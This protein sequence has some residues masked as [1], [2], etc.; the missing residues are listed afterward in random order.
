[1]FRL[2]DNFVDLLEDIPNSLLGLLARIGIFAPFFYVGLTYMSPEASSI[3]ERLH[4]NDQTIMRFRNVFQM[5][6]PELM[7]KI[8]TITHVVLP[9]LILI[10]FFTRISALIL[11][12]VALVIHYVEV[13]TYIEASIFNIDN[14][15]QLMQTLYSPHAMWFLALLYLLKFGPGVLSIDALIRGRS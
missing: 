9:C 3:L 8:A 12:V 1:M 14:V 2:Y 11:V 10:G 5:P 7:A 4:P 15:E 6:M 13:M